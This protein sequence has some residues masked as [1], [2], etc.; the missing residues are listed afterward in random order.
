MKQNNF[1]KGLLINNNDKLIIFFDPLKFGGKSF[2]PNLNSHLEKGLLQLPADTN[3][4]LRSDSKEKNINFFNMGQPWPLFC[5]FDREA[6]TNN[7]ITH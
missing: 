4:K 7:D 3:V 5:I 6:L 1:L 2:F